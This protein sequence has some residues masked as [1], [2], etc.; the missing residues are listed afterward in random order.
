MDIVVIAVMIVVPTVLIARQPD[1]GTSLL[2]AMSGVLVIVLA[3]L[4]IRVMILLGAGG[5]IPGA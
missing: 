1:L 3:G 4:S 2:I 5:S